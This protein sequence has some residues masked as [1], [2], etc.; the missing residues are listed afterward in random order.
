MAQGGRAP[1][2][3]HVRKSPAQYKEECVVGA[4]AH[5]RK[6]DEASVGWGTE[7]E[8]DKDLEAMLNKARELLKKQHR[9]RTT[10]GTGAHWT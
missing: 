10:K 5:G 9:D 4:K 2:T 7:L 3:V 1:T 6:L 8:L